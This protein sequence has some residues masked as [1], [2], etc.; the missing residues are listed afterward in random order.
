M[1]SSSWNVWLCFDAYKNSSGSTF[2]VLE[3]HVGMADPATSDGNHNIKEKFFKTENSVYLSTVMPVQSQVMFVAHTAR[4][5]T[6]PE[7]ADLWYI[8][9]DVA[10]QWP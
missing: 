7:P 5:T 3:S 1:R 2:G 6:G 8:R 9:H 10:A 4:T